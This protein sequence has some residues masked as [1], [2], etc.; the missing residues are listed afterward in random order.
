M[1]IWTV[2]IVFVSVAVIVGTRVTRNP[3]EVSPSINATTVSLQVPSVLLKE[4]TSFSAG[5][6][7]AV[8]VNSPG[9]S[10]ASPVK[11]TGQKLLTSLGKPE[12]LYV[13]A[14]FCPFCAAERWP[15]AVALGRFGTF[16]KL[17]LT[18]SAPSPEI[19]PLT[20]TFTFYKSTYSS[21]YVTFVPVE[22]ET[23]THQPLMVMT[24]SESALVSKYDVEKYL[25][26]NGSGPGGDIPFIDL[27]NRFFQAGASFTP[28]LLA[29]LSQSTIGKG[30][31]NATNPVTDAIVASANYL[32][33]E[34]C[35]LTSE[36]PSRVCSSSGVQAAD[37][38]L[39]LH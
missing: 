25:P 28:A 3:S 26:V 14:E 34:L 15:L 6:T 27:G 7:N 39:G 38:T 16:S 22:V 37:M 13:G 31:S 9:T 23:R 10:V 12:I 4:V 1:I 30:L 8:G 2:M 18:D 29:G 36:Q 11:V 21:K 17:D 35:S 33:A 20:P 5:V 24:K 19:F 32:T